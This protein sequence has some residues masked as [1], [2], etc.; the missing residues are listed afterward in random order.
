MGAGIHFFG[1][2]GRLVV[3]CVNAS[4]FADLAHSRNI[5]AADVYIDLADLLLVQRNL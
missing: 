2:I 1:P 3:L 4:T 5:I